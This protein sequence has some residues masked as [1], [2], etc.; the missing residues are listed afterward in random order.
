M[1]WAWVCLVAII[2][3]GDDA[4]DKTEP[5]EPKPAYD[6]KLDTTRILVDLGRPTA[7][8]STYGF[9]LSATI[10][11]KGLLPKKWTADLVVEVSRREGGAKLFGS[12]LLT[13]P[14]IG[15]ERRF[16]FTK[17]SRKYWS[18]IGRSPFHDEV[19]EAPNLESA[20]FEVSLSELL[21]VVEAE[22]V[23]NIHG[24]ECKVGVD[25]LKRL[26]LGIARALELTD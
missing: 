26:R 6:A 1:R 18:P 9:A 19:K 14:Q 22:G 5:L 21:Q 2:S 11:G 8:K 10:Q 25:G 13:R 16:G 23:L 20:T 7:V 24:V 3:Q 17:N 15:V 4:A 12:N